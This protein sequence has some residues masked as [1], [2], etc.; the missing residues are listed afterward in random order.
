MNK[1]LYNIFIDFEILILKTIIEAYTFKIE[2][3]HKTSNTQVEIDQFNATIDHLQVQ[4]ENFP[5]K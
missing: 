5:E 4:I 1:N 2:L 3:D